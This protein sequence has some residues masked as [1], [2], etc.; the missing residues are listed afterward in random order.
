MAKKKVDNVRAHSSG[1]VAAKVNNFLFSNK[2]TWLRGKL[3]PMNRL[4]PRQQHILKFDKSY[5]LEW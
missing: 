3:A 5:F 1:I 2:K 4:S